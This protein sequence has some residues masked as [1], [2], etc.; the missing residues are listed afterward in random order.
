MLI[1]TCLEYSAAAMFGVLLLRLC[2]ENLFC[3]PSFS[4]QLYCTGWY[5]SPTLLALQQGSLNHLSS[6]SS[7][8]LLPWRIAFSRLSLDKAAI[9]LEEYVLTLVNMSL[10]VLR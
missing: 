4:L 5:C 8:T 3:I 1:T 6:F 10:I 9:D 7:P 2:E